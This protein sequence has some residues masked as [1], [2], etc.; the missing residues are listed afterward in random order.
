MNRE[1]AYNRDK[2]KCKICGHVLKVEN[3]HCHRIDEKLAIDKINTV[4]NLAWLCRDCGKYIHGKEMPEKLG[5]KKVNKIQK[6]RD[7]LN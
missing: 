1:Y 5:Q 3:R 2:G 7:K 4:P 6:Y